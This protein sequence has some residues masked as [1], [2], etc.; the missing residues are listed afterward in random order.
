MDVVTLS[1]PQPPLGPVLVGL[2]KQA[3]VPEVDARVEVDMGPGRDVV[4]AQP[5]V[6][7]EN[8]TF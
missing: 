6:L 2:G 5:R 7:V 4:A 8:Y 1:A 3:R